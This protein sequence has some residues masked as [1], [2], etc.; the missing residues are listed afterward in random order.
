[1]TDLVVA[2]IALGA[3]LDDPVRQVDRGIER[4]REIP[5]TRLLA[6]SSLWRT[7]PVGGAL[8]AGQPD[9]I[10]AVVKVET[11][12]G[13]GALLGILQVVEQDAGRVRDGQ[14][15]MAPRP[16][17]LDLLLYGETRLDTPELTLPHPRMH[18]RAFVLAPL[19][20]IA[21]GLELPPYGRVAD[22]LARLDDQRIEKL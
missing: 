15:P 7:A 5:Q 12:L 11:G 10:N 9:Y 20:E 1:M 16:L 14:A 6:R 22:L 2:Y 3:N 17:D 21:P 18:Q 4:L 13:G 8:V 19:A